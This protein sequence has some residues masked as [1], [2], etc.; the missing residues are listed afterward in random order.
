[1]FIAAT[2]ITALIALVGCA[3]LYSVQMT[4]SSLPQA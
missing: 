4:D 3:L 2:F 1:M